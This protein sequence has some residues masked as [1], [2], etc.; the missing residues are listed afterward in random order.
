[1]DRRFLQG[2]VVE[3]GDMPAID[4]LAKVCEFLRKESVAKITKDGAQ[5]GRASLTA[6]VFVVVGCSLLQCTIRAKVYRTAR[7]S[8]CGSCLVL[9][10]TRRG[11]DALASG[12]VFE[13][14]RS[15]LL[16][17]PMSEAPA[18]PPLEV[19]PTKP[20]GHE[21][22]CGMLGLLLGMLDEAEAAAW[23]ASVAM[24]PAGCGRLLAA[25]P[26]VH[27]VLARLL[28]SARLAVAYPAAVAVAAVLASPH[29]R[30]ACDCAAGARAKLQLAA[31]RAAESA[32]EPLVRSA[33]G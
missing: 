15:Y 14:A 10:I 16:G 12:H 2:T 6:L 26:E 23:A 11:G 7:Q 21:L 9:E 5:T 1:M 13:R 3:L 20:G 17:K 19:P 25:P 27:E 22:Q 30:A 32:N 33:L 28:D 18:P 31:A 4:A 8:G 29:A 24:T